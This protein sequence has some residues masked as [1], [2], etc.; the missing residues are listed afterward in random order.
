FFWPQIT[1]DSDSRP[2]C[3][4]E[5]SS[6]DFV[7]TTL[8]ELRFRRTA[9]GGFLQAVCDGPLRE[10]GARAY[11]VFLLFRLHHV[12]H[13]RLQ[14]TRRG[15]A[16]RRQGEVVGLCRVEHPIVEL[17]THGLVRDELPPCCHQRFHRAAAGCRTQHPCS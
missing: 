9:A 3:P 14:V 5:R 15:L 11:V 13:A 1:Y 17:V 16:L 2:G 4:V 7:A 12:S 6:T 10:R 8:G